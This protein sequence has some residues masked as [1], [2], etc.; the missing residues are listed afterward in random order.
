MS[1]R[2]DGFDVRS[3]AATF[4]SGTELREHLHSWGQLVFAASG[5]MLVEASDAV[6]LVPPTRAIWMPEGEP[7][8]IL[9]KTDVA[10]RT[11]Y[12][13]RNRSA[14]LPLRP[15]V[16]EVRPLLRELVLHIVATGLL[17]PTQLHHDRMA[18]LLV[19]LILS[20]RREDLCLPL[21]Q[22]PRALRLTKH[23]QSNPGDRRHARDLAKT[24][25][26]SL[27]TLQRIFPDETGLTV[28]AWR[29]KARLLDAI[30]KLEAGQSVTNVSSDCGYLSTAAFN[31]AFRRLFGQSPRRY[32]VSTPIDNR[33]PSPDNRRRR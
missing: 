10:M 30:G 4:R 18:G 23:W 21:P 15:C 2:G 6:W 5:V 8:A 7:H 32:V 19:D 25:G 12:L 13:D 14:F 1:D 16:L 27:R 31:T 20:A 9:M 28:E 11:L 33:N 26:A 22:D 3:L 29:Q 24:T 17:D